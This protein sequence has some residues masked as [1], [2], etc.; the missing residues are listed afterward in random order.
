M[1]RLPCTI[2]HICITHIHTCCTRSTHAHTYRCN[3]VAQSRFAVSGSLRLL[4]LGRGLLFILLVCCNISL[5]SFPL[6]STFPWLQKC[7]LSDHWHPRQFCE[8]YRNYVKTLRVQVL[9]TIPTAWAR[10]SDCTRSFNWVVPF[11]LSLVL[12]LSS[13]FRSPPCSRGCFDVFYANIAI[14]VVSPYLF[15][16]SLFVTHILI[17]LSFDHLSLSPL[18]L[19]VSFH[20]DAQITLPSPHR[21]WEILTLAALTTFFMHWTCAWEWG[22]WDTKTIRLDN[23]TW[24]SSQLRNTFASKEYH[25]AICVCIPPPVSLLHSFLAPVSITSSIVYKKKRRTCVNYE[26]RCACGGCQITDAHL[27]AWTIDGNV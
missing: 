1:R 18:S 20:T 15:R 16:F 12:S 21:D 25:G 9:E 24:K 7:T 26:S 23:R 13:L 22:H 11:S 2:A 8:V 27:F 6:N 10:F 4:A 5:H 17:S 14:S 3:A 19:S